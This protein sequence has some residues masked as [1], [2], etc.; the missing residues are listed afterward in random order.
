VQL[1]WLCDIAQLARSQR[2]KWDAVRQQATRLGIERIVAVSL[3]LGHK[4]LGMAPPEQAQTRAADEAIA[5]AIVPIIAQGAE[6]DTESI[7]YFR[8]MMRLRERRRDRLR[9]LWR[10]IVTPSVGEWSV[11]RLPG[12]LFF[13]YRVV[14]VFRLAARVLR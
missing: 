14:R 8:L 1:S 5:C 9:F 2:V 3:V 4:M 13:L 7:S 6:Y 12:P 11:V 10:L